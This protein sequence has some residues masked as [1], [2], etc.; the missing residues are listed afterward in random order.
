MINQNKHFI[1]NTISKRTQM[2]YTPS[3]EQ[4]RWVQFRRQVHQWVPANTHNPSLGRDIN[5]SKRLVCR[6][7]RVEDNLQ[8]LLMRNIYK[9][10]G[11]RRGRDYI[12]VRFTTTYAISG[13]YH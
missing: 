11:G 6:E 10:C 4:S 13:Y 8:H 5:T 1:K 2:Q 12:V 3:N 7:C 9:E